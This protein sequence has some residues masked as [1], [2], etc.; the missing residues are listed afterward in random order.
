MAQ[1]QKLASKY[2]F[3]ILK[4]ARKLGIRLETSLGM[5][6]IKTKT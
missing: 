4:D 5:K 2:S 6:L 3:Q 1:S